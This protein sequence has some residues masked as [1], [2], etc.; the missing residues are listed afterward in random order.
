MPRVLLQGLW[1]PVGAGLRHTLSLSPA[2]AHQALELC[3]GLLRALV[4][5]WKLP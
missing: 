3:P 1:L 4:F 2:P 5:F